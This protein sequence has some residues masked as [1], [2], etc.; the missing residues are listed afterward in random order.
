MLILYSFLIF[1]SGI[2]IGFF[3]RWWLEQ[4]KSYGGIIHVKKE[5]GKTVYLLEVIGDLDNLQ[6]EQQILFKVDSSNVSLD[7]E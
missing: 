3:F 5:S 4:E 7:R 2:I 6:F 1:L